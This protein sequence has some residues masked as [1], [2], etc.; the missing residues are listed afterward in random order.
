MFKKRLKFFIKMTLI[1]FIVILVFKG[2]NNFFVLSK[3]ERFIKEVERY[4]EK[5]KYEKVID[6]L[7]KEYR[8][9]KKD[10]IDVNL[11]YEI[12]K[13]SPDLAYKILEKFSKNKELENLYEKAKKV[14]TMPKL[15]SDLKAYTKGIDVSFEKGSI[16][17]KIYYTK[18]G[19]MPSEDSILYRDFIHIDRSCE[20]KVLVVNGDGVKSEVFN[21]KFNIDR[22]QWL[23]LERAYSEACYVIEQIP[24]GD[25]IGQGNEEIKKELDGYILE[26][27]KV[28]NESLDVKIAKKLEENLKDCSK[29]YKD[30]VLI[31]R[32]KRYLNSV[33]F[34]E[35][36]KYENIVGKHIYKSEDGYLEKQIVVTIEKV[37]EN[38]VYGKIDLSYFNSK[39]KENIIYEG[40]AILEG[41]DIEKPISDE[42]LGYI[43]YKMEDGIETKMAEI[44]YYKYELYL[45]NDKLKVKVWDNIGNIDAVLEKD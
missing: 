37:K 16:G 41:V 42:M 15:N 2:Y 19:S 35:S 28:R 40:I 26:Y 1:M 39:D 43:D 23:E 29:R 20:I 44:F 30:S 5:E 27:S 36:K 45:E 17:E 11:I 34:D 25:K 21:Y 18:D 10:D 32:E 4:L 6:I 38:L 12:D 31:S 13:I 22:R 8:E 33:T 9:I 24:A 3:E 7:N 14:P